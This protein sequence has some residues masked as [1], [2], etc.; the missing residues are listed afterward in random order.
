MKRIAALCLLAAC[1]APAVLPAPPGVAE[2]DPRVVACRTEV[3]ADP[4]LAA[5]ARASPASASADS[6]RRELEAARR[7]AFRRCLA[8]EGIVAGGGIAAPDGPTD[9]WRAP[10][11]RRLSGTAGGLPLGLPRAVGY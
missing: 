3:E 8:R 4:A 9:R 11:E 7:A 6:F 1:G 2:T 10:T 5:L